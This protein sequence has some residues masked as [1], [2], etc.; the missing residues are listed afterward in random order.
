[1][2]GGANG[3]IRIVHL[4]DA[5]AALPIL[6]KWF[7]GEWTPWYGPAGDGDAQADLAA[8]AARDALPLCLVVLNEGSELLGTASLRPESVGSELGVGP[9]LAAFLVGENER[10]RG[11]GT[12][13]V[14]AIE[15]EA[16]RLGYEAIYTSTDSAD[17]IVRRLGWQPFGASESLRGPVAVYRQDLAR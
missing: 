12:A 4:L 10:R 16:R 2:N 6:V 1:M 5:P 14:A 8:C 15:G 11:V 9:W 7:I 17:G 13:L 3:D